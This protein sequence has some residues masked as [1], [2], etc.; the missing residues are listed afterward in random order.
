MADSGFSEL[1]QLFQ[2]AVVAL[3]DGDAGGFIIKQGLRPFF[4]QLNQHV[5]GSRVALH[6]DGIWIDLS[7]IEV[8]TAKQNN[9]DG[10]ASF[11]QTVIIRY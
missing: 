7:Y 9:G 1:H 5:G 11:P 8:H 6:L 3:F 4:M 10:E 2:A